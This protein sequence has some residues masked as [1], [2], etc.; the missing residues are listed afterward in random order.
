MD[1]AKSRVLV[2]DDSAFMRRAISLMLSEDPGID[3]VATARNGR[4][5]VELAAKLRPDVITMDIEMPEMDG[6]TA[7]RRIMREHPTQVLML[8]SL[9]VDGSVAALQAMR[10]GA[11]DVM[12]K[13]N[14]QVSLS[15][16]N[17]KADLLAR[18]K[19]LAAARH[20]A[21]ARPS[22]AAVEP[23]IDQPPVFRPGQFDVV[24]IGSSTGG[25][26]VLETLLANLPA[27]FTTP[28]L[29]AQHMPELFTR[30]MSQRLDD[31]SPLRVVHAE[32]GMTLDKATAYVAP[33]GHHLH[34]HK[35][36]LA[37]YQLRVNH[38]P[39]SAIYRPSVDALL[40][41]AATATTSRTLAIILTG[42]GAD[43]LEGGRFLHAAG[44]TILAQAAESCVVYG[45]PKAVTE[46]G[47]VAAALTPTQMVQSLATLAAGSVPAPALR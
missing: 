2:V 37:R 9:T 27:S 3:V 4:E 10:I 45:M 40:A 8:S 15:I 34:L 32:D 29:I 24:C 18:V 7:L 13:D 23:P 41:S 12:A 16:T 46:N 26:P 31:I 47:L 5:G 43:G 6:L 39:A 1:L 17:I 44:A 20:A 22:V 25:P 38:E 30:S 21:R 35:V 33:G 28:I 42:I 19:A 36:G 11:A 14:S